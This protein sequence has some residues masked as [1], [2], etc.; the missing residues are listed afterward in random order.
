MRTPSP[1]ITI[2]LILG[3]ACADARQPVAPDTDAGF[4][5]SVG[6]DP[7]TI[8]AP[9]FGLGTSP[10]GSILAAETFTGVTELRQSG[11]SLVAALIGVSDIAAIGR[12][13]MLAVTWAGVLG[14]PVHPDARKLFRVSHGGVREIADLD[15][16]EQTVNPDQVWNTAPPESNPFNI[17]Q[18][19]GGKALVADAAANAI[20]FVDEA[21]R[22]DWVAVLTPQL[23]STAPFKALIGCPNPAPECSLPDEMPAQP[24]STSIAVGPDGAYYAGELTGFPGTPGM[25]RIWRIEPGSRHVLCPSAACTMVANGLTSVMDLA[26]GPDGTLYAAEFDAAGWLAVEIVSGAGPLAPVDGGTVQACDV[27]TGVCTPLASGLSLPAAVT[28]GTDG[29]VWVAENNSI[30]GTADIRPIS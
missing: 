22:V 23:V 26:F 9:V 4:A 29:A 1:C 15:E 12:G 25:S 17:A 20:L 18:L 13:D 14:A 10:D 2:A 3:L 27:S 28:V 6:A 19:N 21:G 24:V 30:P 16:Y 11:T 5:A 8:G 7:A